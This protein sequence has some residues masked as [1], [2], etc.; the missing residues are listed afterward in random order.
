M[1]ALT[2]ATGIEQWTG[3]GLN[4]ALTDLTG[5][6]GSSADEASWAITIYGV[7]FAIAVTLSHR[8]AS[9]FGNRRLLTASSAL[10]ALASLGCAA[11]TSLG[12][13][14]CFRTFQG[15]AGGTFLV[16]TL[17]F[18]THRYARQKRAGILR[19][20]GA[21]FFFIG[22]FAAPILAGWFADNMSWR[23]LFLF[24]VPVMALSGWFFHRY[25]A[26]HWNDEVETHTPD[27]LGIVLLVIGVAAAQ[28]ALSRGEI[29]GW[30]E[31]SLIVT[32][33]SVA[34][35][36]NLLFVVWQLVPMNRTPLLHL[37]FL[38]DRGLFSAAVLGI[39]LGM[40]LGG[41]LYVIPQYLRRVE[42]HSAFQTGM[43]MSI[44][45]VTSIGVLLLTPTLARMI[46]KLGGK[47]VMIIALAAQ[48]LSM[49]ML[50]HL[51]TDN[52]PDRDLW[53]PLLLN[54]IFVGIAVPTLALA[55]FARMAEHHSSSARAIYYGARQLGASLGVTLVV[56]LI[57]RRAAF[58]SSRLIDSLFSR[59]LAMLGITADPQTAVGAR[60]LAGMVFKQSLVLTYADVF[61]A[62]AA[63]AAI[64]LLFL[65]LLPSFSSPQR[66]PASRNAL[67]LPGNDS[68]QVIS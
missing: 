36:G 51:L 57:D 27:F 23:F 11:S 19:I 3:S 1:L 12:V 55:A 56:V 9:Y 4:V 16:R 33:A 58:H 31:S 32:M 44:S 13:F 45:G 30:F 53:I 60:K 35:L 21:G 22:R 65:P 17:V 46:G 40:L 5:A 48:M 64:T 50:G 63:L 6:L 66:Q 28:V 7:A 41:S 2:L 62:M 37:A 54:G 24:T 15:L 39:V 34:I 38:R 26:K 49:G 43:L 61:Y 47:S 68:N 25:A 42:S 10:Y 59:N 52:T 20:Y 18:I 14:L 8:L 29:D 67:P